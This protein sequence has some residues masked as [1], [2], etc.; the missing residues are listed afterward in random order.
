MR[1]NAMEIL[2]ENYDSSIDPAEQTFREYV[3]LSAQSDEY[4][5]HWLFD[6]VGDETFKM[7]AEAQEEWESFLQKCSVE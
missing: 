5:F 4:F 2:R 3:E 7:N 1:T 6:A